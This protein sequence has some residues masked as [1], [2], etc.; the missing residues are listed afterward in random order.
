[1]NKSLSSFIEDRIAWELAPNDCDINI[2]VLADQLAFDLETNGYC[3]EPYSKVE[4]ALCCSIN[5]RKEKECK[6][7]TCKNI[8]F[9]RLLR[10]EGYI[11]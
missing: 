3:F 8:E 9:C 4:N 1:M 2:P 7:S 6:V 10:R 5:K 11:Y